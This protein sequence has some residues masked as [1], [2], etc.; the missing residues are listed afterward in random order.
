[1]PT[2][3]TLIALFALGLLGSGHCVGMCGPLIV[4][5]PARVG[6]LSAHLAYNL[7][8]ISMYA[9]VGALLGG[10][11]PGLSRYWAQD[12]FVWTVRIQVTLSLVAAIFMA[13]FGLA[14]LGFLR[15]PRLLAEADTSRFPGV[16]QL[17]GWLR[18]SGRERSSWLPTLAGLYVL[19][20]LLGLLP[21]G[22]SFAAFARALG[23]DGMLGG[24]ISMLAF[25]AGTL[26][27]LLLVGVSASRLTR[28]YRLLS[29]ILAGML[30]IGMSVS[31]LLA[32]V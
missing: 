21:C 18:R 11:G 29:D 4:A 31:L 6:G 19:G 1:M 24:G 15:E 16:S 14:K 30:M 32:L 22:L 3:A 5:F 26:P 10:I 8:R 17:R 25:G 28:R 12:S 20:L 13:V 2:T 27:S 23:S 7:G 9:L